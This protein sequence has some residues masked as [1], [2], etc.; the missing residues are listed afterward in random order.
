MN[1][2]ENLSPKPAPGL[3]AGR[4]WTPP[5]AF[6]LVFTR[7]QAH[8][9][10]HLAEP[11]INTVLQYAPVTGKMHQNSRSALIAAARFAIFAIL[12]RNVQ[13]CRDARIAC[14]AARDFV[15]ACRPVSI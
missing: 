1:F 12:H 11:L 15:S 9:D 14:R 5:C 10:Q 13:V 8:S 6:Y 7:Q 2:I 4:P 3:I